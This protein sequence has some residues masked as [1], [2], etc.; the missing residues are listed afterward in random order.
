MIA[1][2]LNTRRNERAGRFA[3]TTYVDGWG[4]VLH[5]HSTSGLVDPQVP[6]LRMGLLGWASLHCA[7]LE[8]CCCASVAI[9]PV[10]LPE[11]SE[12]SSLSDEREKVISKIFPRIIY[13]QFLCWHLRF[14]MSNMGSWA[15]QGVERALFWR[16]RWFW[17]G[18]PHIELSPLSNSPWCNPWSEAGWSNDADLYFCSERWC[19]LAMGAELDFSEFLSNFLIN[20]IVTVGQAVTWSPWDGKQTC[21]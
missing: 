17:P 12:L 21:K 4:K 14:M 19:W 1:A 2:L 11:A 18:R 6:E 20:Y 13:P 5:Q 10:S 15:A 16:E 8:V 3:H 9:N 7:L